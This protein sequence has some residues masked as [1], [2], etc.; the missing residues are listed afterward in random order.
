MTMAVGSTAAT[1]TY[2]ITIT[3]S[4]GGRLHT[5]TVT[6]TVKLKGDSRASI[7]AAPGS[8]S[9]VQGNSGSLRGHAHG[10]GRSPVF[11]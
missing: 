6:L 3:G 5:T 9:V 11:W 7:T 8:V 4:G 2:P 1:G 10:C